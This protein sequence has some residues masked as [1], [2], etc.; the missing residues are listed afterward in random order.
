VQWGIVENVNVINDTTIELTLNRVF[1]DFLFNVSM[2]GASIV[3][4]TALAADPDTGHHI[5]TGPYT[6]VEFVSNDFVRLTRNDNYWN[7]DMRVVTRDVTLRFVPEMPV[8][9]IRMQRGES[10]LSFGTSAD[11]LPLFQNDP[12][13]FEVVPQTFNTIQGFSFNVL[14][15]ILSDYHLRM[16]IMHATDRDDVAIFAAGDWAQ[17]LNDHNGGG[18]IWGFSTAH[19]NNNIPVIPFD[20]DQARWHLEQSNYNGEE[21]ELAAAIITNIRSSQALQEQWARVGINVRV[22]EFDSPGLNTHMANPD[23]TQMIFFSL[24]MTYAPSS[25]RN[26]FHPDGA[27]NRMQYSNPEVTRLIDEAASMLD[28]TQRRAHYFRIQEIIAEDPPFLQVFWRINGTVAAQG[29]GGIRLPADNLQNDFRE[30][31]YI[32]GYE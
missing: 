30:I 3:S 4:R 26:F 17:G 15:P 18:T 31:Y 13:N 32:I 20:L 27:A 11:D 10:H 12:E 8:R 22:Q 6:V 16:A 2:P 29:I 24:A 25:V 19:R 5:G 1:P 14:D 28:E 9:T 7:P 21:I 23:G